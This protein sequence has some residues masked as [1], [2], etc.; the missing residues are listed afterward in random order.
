MFT[1]FIARLDIS[2]PLAKTCIRTLWDAWV[3][4]TP[5]NIVRT[6]RRR[7][8]EQICREKFPV[9]VY[10]GKVT[11]GGVALPGARRRPTGSWTVVNG[12]LALNRERGAMEAGLVGVAGD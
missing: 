7:D 10:H 6:A 9:G 3:A 2:D 5:A 1:S 11:A 8:L 12:R 4:E